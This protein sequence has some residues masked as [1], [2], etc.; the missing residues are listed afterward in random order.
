VVDECT[1]EARAI[2]VARKSSSN[3]IDTLADPFTTRDEPVPIRLHQGPEFVAEVGKGWIEGAGARTAHIEK[4]H[5]WE[6]A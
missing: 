4:A 2:R 3:V 5:P 1:R 6:M